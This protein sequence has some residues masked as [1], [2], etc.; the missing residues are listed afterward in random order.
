MS[1]KPRKGDVVRP[2]GAIPVILYGKRSLYVIDREIYWMP[3]TTIEN[4][5]YEVSPWPEPRRKNI[6]AI[7]LSGDEMEPDIFLTAAARAAN[8]PWYRR[9][10]LTMGCLVLKMRHALN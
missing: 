1:Y 3:F 4:R 5:L 10:F 9:F 8:P 7:S 2:R 6:N